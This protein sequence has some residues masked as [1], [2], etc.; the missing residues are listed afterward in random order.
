MA[1]TAVHRYREN[2]IE[3]YIYIYILLFSRAKDVA[4]I[5]IN[6]GC[7]KHFSVQGGMGVALMSKPDVAC[8]V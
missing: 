5:D 1:H 8:D 3:Y 4:S 6:M 7:P 2:S